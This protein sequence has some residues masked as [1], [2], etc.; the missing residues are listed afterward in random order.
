MRGSCE[1]QLRR[2]AEG[3][4]EEAADHQRRREVAGAAARADGQR[5]R[6]DLG[7]AE[8]QRA[9]PTP[10]HP[11]GS[12][13][14]AGD[15]DLHR[16]VAAA[17][18]A[19]PLARAA[20][21]CQP[22]NQMIGTQK[23]PSARPPRPGRAQRGIVSAAVTRCTRAQRRQEH[24]RQHRDQQRQ[25][26]VER[27]VL[28]DEREA[29]GVREQRRLA[30]DRDD[31][32]VGDD[33]GEDRRDERVRLEVVAVEHLD[34]EQRGAERRAEHGRDAGRDA[35][36]HQDAP[37]ARRRRRSSHAARSSRARRRSASS[38]PRGRPSRPCPSVKIDASAFTQAT[39]LRTTPPWWWKASII[40]SP[41]PPR[42]SGASSEMM[43]PASAPTAGSS[44]SSQGR[45]RPR[46]ADL[47][48]ERLAV[49]AQRAV[50]AEVLEEQ[51]L[52]H[53]ERGEE[54]GAHQPGRHADDRGVEQR[55]PD[56]P[57]V[58]RG[59]LPAGSSSGA[60]GRRRASWLR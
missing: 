40:A 9:A 18:Q 31:D 27:Q 12:Q 21:G 2:A 53:L 19:E 42:V 44:T 55:A 1:Q 35:G 59:R 37:L 11:P 23:T 17:E 34:G 38:A 14:D 60:R 8:A 25:Q 33:A 24:H 20:P 22:T 7:Q 51:P 56:D 52:H 4:A 10:A 26:R 28:D 54:R 46:L 43:P 29:P 32:R 41:P 3:A 13:S 39:R 6:D 57:Q 30:E 48:Q 58:G 47:G 15:R 16:A 36:H 50:A 45:K 5:R 49:R